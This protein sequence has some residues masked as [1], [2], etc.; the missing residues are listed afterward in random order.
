MI[1]FRYKITH[2]IKPV[3]HHTNKHHA[4]GQKQVKCVLFGQLQALGAKS[5]L[6]K[7]FFGKIFLELVK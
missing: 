6:K 4:I 1:N 2:V 3:L 5:K 7:S